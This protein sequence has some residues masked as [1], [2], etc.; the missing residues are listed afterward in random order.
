MSSDY[1]IV[2]RTCGSYHTEVMA[3]PKPNQR[4]KPRR[5]HCSC[6]G[7]EFEV[8]DAADYVKQHPPNFR[9]CPTCDKEGVELVERNHRQPDQPEDEVV[10]LYRCSLCGQE[11]LKLVQKSAHVLYD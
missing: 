3:W 11:I 9:R 1:I 10:D 4:P 8:S 5:Y 6:C 7:D 2:C